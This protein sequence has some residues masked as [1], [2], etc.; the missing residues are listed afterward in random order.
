MALRDGGGP[1]AHAP[2]D[3]FQDDLA[4]IAQATAGDA[5]ARRQLATR[6]I[7]RAWRT[8]RALVPVEADARDLL[9]E[10]LVEILR[11]TR[12]YSGR[13]PLEGWAD[14]IVVRRVMRWFRTSRKARD[15]RDR[16]DA[17]EAVSEPLP[18]ARLLAEG[19]ARPVE[20]YLA[21]LSEPLRTT[22][23]LRH[24]LGHSIPEIATITGA[25]PKRVQKRI[26]RAVAKLRAAI[27]A[28]GSSP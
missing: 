15:R 24:A 17:P 13:A 10:S 5:T 14:R 2:G 22:L 1:G 4:L 7:R 3:A 18:P 23:I 6:L 21:E 26:A 27:A 9:Q 11:N 28:E 12:T 16:L 19:L 20:D 25:S 8:V